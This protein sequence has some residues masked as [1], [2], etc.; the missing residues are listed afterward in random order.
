MVQGLCNSSLLAVS[1]WVNMPR[2]SLRV[3]GMQ[4]CMSI[5]LHAGD[6]IARTHDTHK[7]R[8][9]EHKHSN[10]MLAS[11]SP[12]TRTSMIHWLSADNWLS[13][14]IFFQ[15][16]LR[17]RTLYCQRYQTNVCPCR[18]KSESVTRRS[19]HLTPCGRRSPPFLFLHAEK[20]G[21]TLIT[22]SLG[23]RPSTRWGHSSASMRST[24]ISSTGQAHLS[25]KA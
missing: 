13:C 7:V 3:H 23:R 16:P 10:C 17:A 19:R 12:S 5:E 25:L 18:H 2:H 20:H 6:V 24:A 9:V 15:L 21:T 22:K 4:G 8:H 1:C 14:V 11:R